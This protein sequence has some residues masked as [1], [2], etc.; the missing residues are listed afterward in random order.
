MPTPLSLFTPGIGPPGG[1]AR[2]MKR[3][4]VSAGVAAVFAAFCATFAQADVGDALATHIVPAAN[5]AIKN[6]LPVT[7]VGQVPPGIPKPA[8]QQQAGLPKGFTYT[9]DVSVAYPFGN[10]GTYGAKWL[11]GGWD[12]V[13]AYGFS[14]R[15]R[16][17]ASYYEL[18]HYPV[19][20]NSGTVPLFIQGLAP[21]VGSVDLANNP[22][23][24]TDVTVKDRFLL[25]MAEHLFTIGKV[26]IVITPTYVSRWSTIG[27]SNGNAD[28]I[29]FEFNGFPQYGIKT[30]TAQI[31]VAAVTLPFLSTPKMFGTLTLAPAWLT[32]LNGVNQTNH[33]QLYQ[34]LYLEYNPTTRDKFFFE[35]L[36]SRSYL[37]TDPYPQHLNTYFLGYS[38]KF[39]PQSFVQL[40]LNSGG[41]SNYTP[42]G[43][44]SLYCQRLP[45]AAPGN[46]IPQ[47]GGLKSTQLQLQFGI[48][49]PSVIQI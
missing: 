23:G 17:Q 38:H 45:C 29:P 16:F 15:F 4:F 3:A 14:S 6:A 34:I 11:P 26:P 12:A 22:T 44:V 8:A 32:H 47:L 7:T 19:G 41:P 30:R 2:R 18:Q 43:I 36:A 13:A 42:Y 5:I 20:F 39:T 1:V 46:T 25:L 27:A 9:A 33:A 10:V 37:P 31:H 24:P 40:V 28:V 35:P 48:G 21:P 49:S